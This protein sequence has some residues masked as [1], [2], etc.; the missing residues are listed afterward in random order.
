M[1]F[2]E[3][4][5]SNFAYYGNR[6]ACYMMTKDFRSALNDA[7]KSTAINPLFFKGYHREAKCHMALGA[8]STAKKCLEKAL[9]VEPN[10]YQ[11]AQDVSW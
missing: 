2:P 8:S 6:C 3:L 10:N 7:R 11:I 4:Q 9:D 5:P 1:S